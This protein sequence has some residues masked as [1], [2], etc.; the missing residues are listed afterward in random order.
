MSHTVALMPW[1]QTHSTHMLCT[2]HAITLCNVKEH[3]LNTSSQIQDCS[4]LLQCSDCADGGFLSVGM[5]SSVMES[6]DLQHSSMLIAQ[7]ARIKKKNEYNFGF[8]SIGVFGFETAVGVDL[9][10]IFKNIK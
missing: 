5:N 9:S 6:P 8:N 3:H 4:R 10:F 2:V 7:H 1:F